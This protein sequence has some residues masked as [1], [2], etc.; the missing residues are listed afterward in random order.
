[1]SVRERILA[2]LE[3]ADG[4]I[5]DDCMVSSAQIKHR[6]QSN[7][8]CRQLTDEKRILR[9]RGLCLACKRIKKVNARRDRPSVSDPRTLAPASGPSRLDLGSVDLE[10]S[11]LEFLHGNAATGA[12][13]RGPRDR[14]ASFD[15][16]FNYFQS[17]READ[18]TETLVSPEHLQQSCLQLGFYL[19]SWGMLR[20]STF[21]LK[22]SLAIYEPVVRAVA[23][24]DPAVWGIDAHC[25]TE[26]NVTKLLECRKNIR[27]AFG[28]ENRASDTLVTK[29]MLGVFGNVP[30]FDTFVCTALSELLGVRSFGRRSLRALGRF[31]EAHSDVIERHR[32]A[33]LAFATG[34]ETRR[35]Y[36]RAKVLDM[37]FFIRGQQLDRQRD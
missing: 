33:T 11:I 17:F 20:G 4:A 13:G 30:A 1:M 3:R 10:R 12:R 36:T 25:Y 9:G 37:A 2:A 7:S 8:N 15:Y 14:Y 16:C 34:G 23:R 31:Y 24:M 27:A 19:A 26:E 6:Q 35:R 5:C 18:A 29:V 32:V 22:H 28:D 21:L